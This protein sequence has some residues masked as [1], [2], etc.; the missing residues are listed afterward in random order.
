M[1]PFAG[2]IKKGS[3]MIDPIMLHILTWNKPVE[4]PPTALVAILAHKK[5]LRKRKLIPYM[6]GSVMPQKASDIWETKCSNR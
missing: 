2:S 3:P 1:I 5:G 4:N 6:A